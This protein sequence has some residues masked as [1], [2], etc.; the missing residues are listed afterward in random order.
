LDFGGARQPDGQG[1]AAFGEIVSGFDALEAVFRKAESD[2]FL[3]EPI[4]ILAIRLING[5]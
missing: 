4:P 2:E 1:F 5:E 3:E